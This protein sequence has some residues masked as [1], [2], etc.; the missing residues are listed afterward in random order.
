MEDQNKTKRQLINEL[1]E[2]RQRIVGLEALKNEPKHVEEALRKSEET[3]RRLAQENATMA[4]IGRIISSTLNIEE[5]YE[6]FAEEARKL[7][8]FDRIAISLTDLKNNT[9]TA[10]YIAGIDVPG[11]GPVDIIPMAGTVAEEVTRT[12]SGLLIQGDNINEVASRFPALLP[13]F[14]AGLRSLIFVP[15]ISKNQVIGVLSLRSLVPKAYTDQDVRLAES[16]GNQIAGAIANAQL[17]IELKRAEEELQRS[18]EEARRLAQENAIMAE[19]GR[20]ISSTL[21]IEEVYERFAEEVRKLI[22]F[23]RI[24]LSTFNPENHSSTMAYALGV[25]VEDRKHGTVFPLTGSFYEELIAKRSG[26]I[27][28]TE[29]EKELEEHYPTLLSTFQAGI[30]S[31][32]SVPLISKDQVMGVLHFRSLKPNAYT[33]LDLKLAER[34]GNQI[35]GA[36]ANAQLFAER[37]QVEEALR[38]EKQRFQT[39]SE[40]APFG[41]AMIDQTGT[42]KYIN[43]KYK[44]LLGYDL[45]EIPDG[46]T[47]YR[48]AFPDPAYRHHAISVWINDNRLGSPKPGEKI[49]RTF[50]ITC[51]DGTEKIIDFLP[52]KLETGEYLT[53]LVDI[54]LRKKAE[55][56]L[57]GSEEAATRLAQ[58]NAT[59]AE[60]GRIISSTLD[61][62]EIYERFA[63]EVRILIPFDRIIINIINPE[64]KTAIIAYILGVDV[65]D[66]RIGDF[67]SLT[68][69]ATGECIRTR[70]SILFQTENIDE[71]ANR[72]PGLLSTFK[73]GLRSMI[74]IPLISKDQVIGTLFL[75]ATKLNAY[76]ERELRLAER[77]GN[78][79]A[80]AIA[81]AQ[82][83]TER[84][85]AE[86]EL[87]KAYM[88]LKG[89]Q[90]QLIQSEKMASIGQL[91]AGIAHEINNPAGF[92][93][94]NLDILNKYIGRITPIFQR[95]VQ[96][97]TSLA[98]YQIPELS[99]L[100][101]EI[102]DLRDHSA[103]D[104]ILT[105]LPQIVSE[106]LEGTQRIKKI[107]HDLRTFS[108]AEAIEPKYAFVND[109]LDFSL[110]LIWNEI[111]HKAEVVKEYS[112]VPKLFCYPQQLRQ[113]FLNILKNAVQAIEKR[114]KIIIKT[115]EENNNIFIEIIDTGCGIPEELQNRIFEPFFTMKEV[116]KGTGLGLSIVYGIIKKHK[117]DITVKSK[118][119]EGTNFI[120]K[121]PIGGQDKY[122]G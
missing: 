7:I 99:H 55:D 3:A 114:G 15:L 89:T 25:E 101:R 36:I 84:K 115:Y 109:L 110:N 69:S 98:Q 80:G 100:T 74:F 82:L 70:S 23:D 33:E 37:K 6:R 53:S 83:F 93:I 57:Q 111:K 119:G 18:E 67:V 65:K 27:I 63:E 85:L 35:A 112:D 78:Q 43:P 4:E 48:K 62:N 68:D 13:T 40:N 95:Y 73:A 59:V 107:V 30:R 91:A 61:I 97:E 64:N 41:M 29:D 103:M 116:G 22:P 5:V 8:P 117:G 9:S 92:I 34:V 10:A 19:I 12:R 71:V 1:E 104:H 20:I 2:F 46:K 50:T 102:K 86:E 11:R 76:S 49:S 75:Q 121:L 87:K 58:E 52:V 44:E 108:H 24:A 16:I 120:I 38:T 106:S 96:L 45:N 113:V 21:N 118:I 14:Q 94:S 105:D 32:M 28:Q 56:A 90:A 39:V 77:V 42:I 54:T 51:K 60:I 79:I 66:R 88:K 17:F 81:N 122:E 47:W 31:I 72:F 26:I